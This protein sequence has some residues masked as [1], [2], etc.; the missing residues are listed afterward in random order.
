M[1]FIG[2]DGGGTKTAFSLYD[3]DLR[4]IDTLQGP[5][6]HFAQ[7]GLDGMLR[8]LADGIGT[9]ARRNGVED[10]GIGFGLAGYGAQRSVRERIEECVGKVAGGH[11]FELVSDGQAARA[12]AL[13]LAD[14]I[15]L[16]SGTGSIG[17]G[18]RGGIERRCGGW[19]YQVGDEGSGW[20][21]GKRLLAAF[22]RESDGRSPRGALHDVVMRELTLSEE[23]DVIGY[24]RDTLGDDRTKVAALGRLAAEAARQ[25][26]PV[27]RAIYE[28]AARELAQLARALVDEL[29]AGDA[30][31]GAGAGEADAA[32]TEPGAAAGA[33][34]G[35]EPGAA[36]GAPVRTTY[37]GGVFR[38]GPPT[39]PT[40]ARFCS[41][42]AALSA[43]RADAGRRTDERNEP[44]RRRRRAR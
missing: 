39:T 26:D 18:V 35:A 19:G 6:S 22:A 38:V 33:A 1:H 12:A 23:Y 2:V 36:A 14:G 43:R 17:Y 42:A 3:G 29:F 34:A 44:R 30:A 31:A 7:A 15:V 41:C 20:W 32:G 21:I 10:Y 5:T 9:L 16:V 37:V 28:D 24:V 25:G 27:A 4:R 13:D 40:S 8:V 11:P